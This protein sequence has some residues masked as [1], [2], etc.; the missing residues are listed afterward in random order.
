MTPARAPWL[1]T[2]AAVAALV[3]VG[4]LVSAKAAVQAWFVGFVF[5][6]GFPI[7]ATVLL[8]I[9]R[10]VGGR[11]VETFRPQLR[12]LAA[13]TPWLFLF[14]VPML[15][16]PALVFAWADRPGATPDLLKAYLSPAL[17]D[18]RTLLALAVWSGLG[19]AF[20]L[21]RPGAPVAAVGLILHGLLLVVIPNDWLLSLRPG[22][23]TSDIA[24]IGAAIQIL[25]AAALLLIRDAGRPTPAAADL[26]GFVAAMILALIYFGFMSFLVVWYGDLPDRNG[27][28]LARRAE[29][30]TYA[31]VVATGLAIA[32][33][34][35]LGLDARRFGP[36]R[37]AGSAW[38]ALLGVLVFLVWLMGPALALAACGLAAIAVIAQVAWL[39]GPPAWPAP[40][41][42]RRPRHA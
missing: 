6:S 29:P 20:S 18:L 40:P 3:A 37:F 21:G 26:A 31:P 42:A 5:A 9:G 23:T 7:G 12:S 27:F 34:A 35:V 15:V 8:M 22:W 13:R 14:A 16:A 39:L 28:F 41:P 2:L 36:G 33:L 24:M 25:S 17:F 32:A 30:W 4:V 19:L 1:L 10:L 38:L 11:W